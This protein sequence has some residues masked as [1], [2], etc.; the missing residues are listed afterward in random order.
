[1]QRSEAE[2]F[3]KTEMPRD[4]TVFLVSRRQRR[5]GTCEGRAEFDRDPIDVYVQEQMLNYLQDRH[6][7]R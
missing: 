6:F 7:Q 4:I 5:C 3:D 2:S 1:M